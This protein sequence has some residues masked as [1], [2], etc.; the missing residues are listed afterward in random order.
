[1]ARPF[2]P[3]PLGSAPS[4]E[5]NPFGSA[6]S[7]EPDP[8]SRNAHPSHQSLGNRTLPEAA[9]GPPEKLAADPAPEFG[10][11]RCQRFLGGLLRHYYR[12]A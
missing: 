5:L 4:F 11:V 10:R 6:R 12:A 8:R 2:E 7:S 9:T 1:L 3:N